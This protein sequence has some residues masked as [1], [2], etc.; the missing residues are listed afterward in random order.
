[1][2]QL[3]I[4]SILIRNLSFFRYWACLVIVKAPNLKPK[5]CIPVMLTTSLLIW[6]VPMRILQ[7][8]GHSSPQS[9]DDFVRVTSQVILQLIL[10]H[11]HPYPSHLFRY[12]AISVPGKMYTPYHDPNYNPYSRG[13]LIGTAILF[14]I[15]SVIAVGLR[16]YAR[17][18]IK[19]PLGW[20][21]WITI[22]SMVICV[23]LSVNQIIGT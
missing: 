22:P 12:T 16:F 4:Q 6:Y 20:D 11:V 14:I 1:M 7:W 2:Q 3:L 17:R 18:L 23:G 9:P 13:V 10:L 8:C 19:S 15:T 21:D 5:A